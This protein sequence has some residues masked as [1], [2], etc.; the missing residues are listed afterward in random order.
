VFGQVSERDG[1]VLAPDDEQRRRVTLV[2]LGKGAVLA[3]WLVR[4]L[5]A[6]M[7]ETEQW[8]SGTT[9]GEPRYRNA[10]QPAASVSRE[11]VVLDEQVWD[12]PAGAR[13]DTE[14]ERSSGGWQERALRAGE[15]YGVLPR[16]GVV[17]GRGP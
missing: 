12:S 5:A 3:R 15:L 14:P 9:D 1:E 8:G 2:L 13:D 10:R 11:R 6:E 7:D 16:G 4:P 17:R